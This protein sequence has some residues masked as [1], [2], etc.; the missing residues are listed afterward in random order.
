MQKADVIDY[1]GG[2][3]SAAK[4]LGITSNAVSQ[5][6]ESVP[7]LRQYQ[8]ERITRGKLKADVAKHSAT[9]L[10]AASAPQP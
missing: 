9:A 4:A 2:V 7:P 3:S 8:I 1:F 10:P 6:G 5:W